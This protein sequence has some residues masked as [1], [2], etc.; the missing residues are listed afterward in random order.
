MDATLIRLLG[1]FLPNM[2][3]GTIIGKLA[4]RTDPAAALAVLHKN[5][6]RFIY[7]LLFLQ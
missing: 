1:A 2:V 5:F 4:A 3:A 7:Y 6:L